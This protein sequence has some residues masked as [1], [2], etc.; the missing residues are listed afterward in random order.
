MRNMITALLILSL[1]CAGAAPKLADVLNRVD[2]QKL[3]RCAELGLNRDAAVCLGAAAMTEGL[4][5]AV[6]EARQLIERAQE[7]ANPEAGA[8]DMSEA[9]KAQLAADIDAALATVAAEVKAAS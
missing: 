3:I 5:L 9:D 6:E 1:G 8:A 4:R 7:A 2:A